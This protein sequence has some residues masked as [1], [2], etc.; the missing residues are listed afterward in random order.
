[1]GLFTFPLVLDS[2]SCLLL[3]AS[4]DQTVL[5]W[6]WNVE[7]NKV[8]ALHCCRGHAGS[9]DAIAVDSSGAK[10]SSRRAVTVVISVFIL[11]LS[12]LLNTQKLKIVRF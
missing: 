2:L 1:M 4:M 7:K 3:T 12:N 11:V 5:L 10:V 9:V 6:E 8:K